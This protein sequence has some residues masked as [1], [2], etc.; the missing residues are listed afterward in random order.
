MSNPQPLATGA[1]AA[2]SSTRTLGPLVTGSGGVRLVTWDL[3]GEGP[4]LLLSHA[5]G[6]HGLTWE[7]MAAVLGTRYRVWAFDHRGHGGSGHAPDGR[8]DDWR[9]FAEDVLAVVD[10]LA[11]A[12]LLDP[13]ELRAGGH[14]MG[15]SALLLAAQRRR[16]LFRAIFCYEPIIAP[17]PPRG[18]EPA[19]TPLVAATLRRR[20]AFPSLDA[21]RENYASKPP[22]KT[23][24]PAA[25]D[26]YLEGGLEARADGTVAL[27]CRPAEEAS[28]Y[29]GGFAHDCYQHLGELNVPVTIAKAEHGHPLDLDRLPSRLPRSRFHTVRGA[30]HF[31]PMEEPERLAAI[32]LDAM[33]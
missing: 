25:L 2:G 13:R 3:G 4:P 12:S 27:R 5:A 18:R 11:N 29:A 16:E 24:T 17:P 15:A 8:Y 9:R 22:F 30:T 28:V 19:T 14:S 31:A 10:T 33:G 1:A 26:L 7:P 20:E 6:F 21:A 32:V 23:F